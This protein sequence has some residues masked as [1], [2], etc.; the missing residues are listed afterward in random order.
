MGSVDF[1]IRSVPHCHAVLLAFALPALGYAI[2]MH[3]YCL[4]GKPC[5]NTSEFQSKCYT[6]KYRIAQNFDSEKV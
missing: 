4:I 3:A 2:D 1:G 6:S 5:S